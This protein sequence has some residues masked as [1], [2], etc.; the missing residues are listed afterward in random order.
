[1]EKE[2]YVYVLQDSTKKLPKRDKC[3]LS[4]KPFYVGKG[5]GN[6]SQVHT[7]NAEKHNYSHNYKLLNEIVDIKKRGGKVIVSLIFHSMDEDA[8]YEKEK[9][10]ILFYGLRH[11][12]GI[13]VNA[14]SG[15]SGGWGAE[16]NPT[17]ER[18]NSGSHNFQTSNPQI[19]NPK[20]ILLSKMIRSV[21]KKG[22][23]IE[24]EGWVEKAEYANIKA[25]RIGIIRVII[26][27]GLP[28][29]LSSNLLKRI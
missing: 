12:G 13:L 29:K 10:T 19:I 3:N 26:R 1:M 24:T 15:K 17:Y 28:Y 20:L 9:S 5:F 2:Y 25:L 4:Y 16:R 6:R 18:M 21:D 14:S 22:I 27:E 8:V 11:K 23:N 7:Y